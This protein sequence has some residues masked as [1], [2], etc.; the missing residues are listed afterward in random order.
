MGAGDEAYQTDLRCLRA[1]TAK[2]HLQ[3]FRV[4]VWRDE[5]LDL[6]DARYQGRQQFKETVERKSSLGLRLSITGTER[7]ITVVLV[8][9]N[10]CLRFIAVPPWR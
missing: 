8:P 10:L 4:G 1:Y 7:K 3:L 6:L 2:R 5:S 9:L